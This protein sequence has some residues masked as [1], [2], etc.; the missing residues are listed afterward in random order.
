MTRS[1]FGRNTAQHFE[2]LALACLLEAPR[3]STIAGPINL[4]SVKIDLICLVFSEI[5]RI[6][7]H[8]NYIHDR[9]EDSNGSLSHL[10]RFVSALSIAGDGRMGSAV[11]KPAVKNYETLHIPPPSSTEV[12][13]ELARLL[14]EEK[15]RNGGGGPETAA[16]GDGSGVDPDP[17]TPNEGEKEPE[18]EVPTQ[19]HKRP[20][21]AF[22]MKTGTCKF[23]PSCRDRIRRV[24][25]VIIGELYGLDRRSGRRTT[26]KMLSFYNGTLV[27]GFIHC[28]TSSNKK[29][30]GL[31]SPS[32]PSYPF[33]KNDMG[34]QKGPP[35]KK[36]DKVE[37][38]TSSRR[39]EQE[40]SKIAEKRSNEAISGKTGIIEC[41]FYTTPG[42]CKYGNSCKYAHFP[43]KIEVTPIV[44]NFLGLPIRPGMKECPYYM[45][46]GN[47]KYTVNCKYH[48]PN[49]TIATDEQGALPDCQIIGSE[50]HIALGVSGP[51]AIPIPAQGT[52]YV[53]TPLTV[54]SPSYF[55]E[56]NLHPQVFPFHSSS[57]FNDY[58]IDADEFRKAKQTTVRILDHHPKVHLQ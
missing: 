30:A 56:P 19:F 8:S 22:F 34:K 24:C 29:A 7:R 11:G 9:D 52:F 53:P 5:H 55:P 23:G 38:Q 44:L 3:H 2:R 4:F 50:R 49:P 20:D 6:G 15:T 47:C 58:Q 21:C 46:T 31:K 43:K 17:G 18:K 28:R 32:M 54:A 41:K 37:L 33:Q 14:M 16:A 57:Q 45:R 35:F 1:Y 36:V 27:T 25:L 10:L 12:L 13:T 40:D 39:L 51:P 48:H 42:G 26:G